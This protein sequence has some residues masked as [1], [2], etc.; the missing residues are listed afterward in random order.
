MK[1]LIT[2]ALIVGVTN[3]VEVVAVNANA[4]SLTQVLIA[5]IGSIPAM[6]GVLGAIYIQAKNQKAALVATEAKIDT[7]LEVIHTNVN[8]K[9]SQLTE[10]I[11]AAKLAEGELKG[12]AE[13]SSDARQDTASMLQAASSLVTAVTDSIKPVPVAPTPVT[14][15]PKV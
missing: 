12:R 9:V 2:V 15:N 13:A 10:A 1:T 14:T 7:K 11:S 8:S 4:I 5:L 6:L 3:A